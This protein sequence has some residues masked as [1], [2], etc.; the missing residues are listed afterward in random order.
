[1]D[2]KKR[3]RGTPPTFVGDT[4]TSKRRLSSRSITKLKDK[5]VFLSNSRVINRVGDAQIKTSCDCNQS[6]DVVKLCFY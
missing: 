1:M 3:F 4:Q 6:H 2:I 5:R